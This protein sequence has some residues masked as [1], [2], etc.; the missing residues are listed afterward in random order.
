MTSQQL[1]YFSK[2]FHDFLKVNKRHIIINVHIIL[3][4]VIVNKKT[5]IVYVQV[6][7]GIIFNA[8]DNKVYKCKNN[9]F[10]VYVIFLK[11]NYFR[12]TQLLVIVFKFEFYHLYNNVLSYVQAM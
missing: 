5:P 1:F 3:F 6:L 4:F 2:L 12:F 10:S 11:Y 8:Y 7:D 9:V